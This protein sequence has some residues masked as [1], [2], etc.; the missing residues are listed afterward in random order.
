MTAA[1]VCVLVF[2]L[3]APTVAQPGGWALEF[4]GGS[5]TPTS[6]ISSRL[7]TG[8][9]I[10]TGLGYRFNSYFTLFGE[11]GFANMPIPP[12]VL[13]QLQAPEGHGHVL[14][15]NAEPEVRFGLPKHLG[16]FVHGGVG[17]M[18]RNVALTAPSIQQVDFFDPFYGDVPQE[19]VT[20]QVLSSTTRNSWAGNIGGGVALP[21]ASTG[22]EIFLDVRYY[23]APTSPSQTAMVPVTFGIRYT[24]PK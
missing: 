19:I 23:Y 16:G 2:G 17:W 18:R 20:D 15:L 8:W 24:A 3:A 22:A 11:F 21:I 1:T 9:D 4:S 6:D 10:N 7:A 13:Q 14:S 12:D 5:A